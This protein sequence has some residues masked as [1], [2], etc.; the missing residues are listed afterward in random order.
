MFRRSLPVIVPIL[1]SCA[2]LA[3]AEWGDIEGRIEYAW[4]TEDVRALRGVVASLEVGARDDAL[5][6]YYL[7][8]GEYRV[9]L[10]ARGHDDGAARAA[11]EACI[12]H[13]DAA[14]AARRDFADALALQSAC[15]SLVMDMKAW[16]VPLLA[17]RRTAQLE[18][19]RM[20]E[21]RNPRVLLLAALAEGERDRDIGRLQKAV[22]AFETERQGVAPTPAW[23][24][25]DAYLQLAR[26]ELVRG[27]GAAA[28]NALERALLLAP[29]FGG[30]RRLLATIT[31]G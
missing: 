4:Y 14:N 2:P 8:L 24:A 17:P 26:G 23:G 16:K 22:D 5:R 10:L 6:A 9:A 15:Q 13:L 12:D 1:F 3:A 27:D 30:A 25:P 20:L 29:D 11:A 28:R 18:R 7:G 19:A 31:A 21:P